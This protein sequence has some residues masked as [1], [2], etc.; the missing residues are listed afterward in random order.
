MMKLFLHEFFSFHYQIFIFIFLVSYKENWKKYGVCTWWL[1]VFLYVIPA[2]IYYATTGAVLYNHPIFTLN[3]W[4]SF[5][6]I[7]TMIYAGMILYGCCRIKIKPTIFLLMSAYLLQHLT[8]DIFDV[9]TVIL[10]VDNM[11][12]GFQCAKF[13]LFWGFLIFYQ[14]CIRPHVRKDIKEINMKSGQMIWFLIVSFILINILTSWIYH[15]ENGMLQ[16]HMGYYIYGIFSSI[17]LL[18]IQYGMLDLTEALR[19]KNIMYDMMRNMEIQ[20]QNLKENIELLNEKYHD[21]KYVLL[22]SAKENE[23]EN[24]E[25]Y[26][27][28]SLQLI[29]D[30]QN[31]FQTG[32]EAMDVLLTEKSTI[33]RKN[34]IILTCFID[35]KLL[36][37][38][39]SEDVYILFGNAMDNAIEALLKLQE[40]AQKT[41]FLEVKRKNNFITINMENPCGDGISFEK[42]IP[43]T[44]KK[45]T[46]FHGIGTKSMN[47]I[48]KKYGGNMVMKCVNNIFMVQC[49]IPYEKE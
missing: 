28:K 29:E 48:V 38:M 5:Y 3:G 14:I 7:E 39:K 2:T 42:G 41:I 43:I 32:C 44:S 16:N 31:M 4:Y 40:D 37:Y 25:E 13:L 12:L 11:Q 23:K 17:L 34:N 26:I 24:N 21:F 19:E 15:Y 46:M 45:D 18:I 22:E 35:G 47:Y 27:N 33:C 10:S 1:L 49:I 30:Y 9:V 6:Y 36:S 20:Y 8:A